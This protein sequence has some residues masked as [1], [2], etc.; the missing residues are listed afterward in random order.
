MPASQRQARSLSP[1]AA[2]IVANR[3]AIG[4]E[5]YL[6]QNFIRIMTDS[7]QLAESPEFTNLYMD[8]ERTTRVT[9]R[10]LKK[11]EKRLATAEKKGQD[12]HHEVFDEMRIEIVAELATPTFRKEVDERLQTLLDR[13]M[14]TNDLE[15]LEL[16]MVLKPMLSTKSI[17]WGLCGLILEI[18]GRTMQRAMQEFE[19]DQGFYD[20]VVE[21]LK[22]EGIDDLDLQT[23]L[24][25]PDKLEQVGQKVFEAQPDLRQRA[26]N[27]IWEMVEA[28]EDKL[29]RGDV[30]LSLFSEEELMLPFQR[31]QAEFGEPFTQAQPSEEL[32]ERTFDAIRQ[33]INE[34]M[35]PERFRRFC[36]EVE[37]TAK[38]WFHTRQ[39][40]AA[41]LQFELGYLDGD[42]Y[43][44]NKFVL[45]AFIGQIYRLGKEHKPTRKAKNR[46]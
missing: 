19:E 5:D 6:M 42:Q 7:A 8:S 30:D 10:W 41:A 9:E 23:I 37:M 31:I 11:Y 21:A 16:V 22:A 25:H 32:R 14:L 18:Y 27:Q 40:W 13:L 3:I 36:E 15:K 26:E 39:K 2:Q 45:A 1:A 29:G 17:P 46:H 4:G 24:E 35:T 43:E 38:T 33:A 20:S 12:A 44:E 28:F 34:I